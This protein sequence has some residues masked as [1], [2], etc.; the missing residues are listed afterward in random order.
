MHERGLLQMQHQ[1][2]GYGAPL[3]ADTAWHLATKS[4]LTTTDHT[5]TQQILQ[6]MHCGE[7]GLL[8]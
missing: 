1:R 8:L 3:I 7:P 6:R 4:A 2:P 5:P